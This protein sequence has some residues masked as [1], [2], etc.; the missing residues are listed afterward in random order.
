MKGI[1][2]GRILIAISSVLLA[3]AAW[4]QEPGPGRMG[5]PDMG[6]R[7]P[8]MERSFGEHHFEMR[9][10]NN[11]RMIEKLKLTDDQ[12]KAFDQILQAHREKLIDLRANLEK[13]ELVMEPLM[14]ADQPDEA[15]ILAQIDKV[16]QARAELE[17]ANARYLMEQ[18]SKLTADQWKLMKEMRE[19][20]RSMR[21]GGA[22]DSR[23]PWG[24]R[25]PGERGKGTQATPPPPG[26]QGALDDDSAPAP[27]LGGPV[28]SA[29][30]AQ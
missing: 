4:G 20:R 21:D 17:K 2:A 6:P 8:P 15:K 11:P 27:G 3:T 1:R 9:W 14:G 24:G 10:W 18:R 7:R 13:A 28:P 16:A 22:P 5:P 26:A 23:R 19:N 25:E 30:P 29:G 12:R